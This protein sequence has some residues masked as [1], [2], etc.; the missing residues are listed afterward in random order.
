VATNNTTNQTPKKRQ[1]VPRPRTAPKFNPRAR[2]LRSFLF[3]LRVVAQTYVW[4]IFLTRFFITRWYVRRHAMD[5]WMKI[6]RRFRRLAI[7]MGGMQIKLGQFLSSRADIIPDPI[8]FE[9][10]GLQDEVPGAP[11]SHVLELIMEEHGQHPDDLFLSFDQESVAAASLGQVHYATLHD[12]SSV[13]VKVQRPYIEEIIDVDLSAV[14]WILRLIKDYPLVRK[15]ADVM[16]LYDEFAVVLRQELDYVQESHNAETLR[17]NFAGV[18]GVYI[19]QPVT[20]MTTRRV[21]VMERIS[22][23]KI[24]DRAA[25]EAAGISRY[26]L[27]DRLNQSYLKQFFLDGFF[28]ADPHP[29]NLFVR[30]EEIDSTVNGFSLFG[31]SNQTSL[32]GNAPPPGKPFTLIFVDFGMVGYL[33]PSTMAV[34]RDGVL[35]LATNDAERIV[36]ALYELNMFLPDTDKRP[37]IKIINVMLKH[38]YNRTVRELNNMDI[39]RLFDETHDLVYDMPFQI[40]K[41]LL[42]LGRAVSMVSGLATEIDPDINLFESLRPFARKMLEQE[43]QQ[44]NWV[45]MAQKEI[46]DLGTILRDLPRQMAT[47]YQSANYGELQVRTDFTRME[48]MVR[49]VERSTDRL[50]GGML[51]TGLFLGGV[52][53]RMRGMEKEARQAWM[54]AALALLWSNWPRGNGR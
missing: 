35:G 7:S 41:D 16:A 22:G 44:T 5:R 45:E 11:A 13:A 19:P 50:T 24:S 39:E 54:A 38:T 20:E 49:R 12:G 36:N 51:A 53:L 43:R 46:G 8:R 52:Q 37:I 4:D 32:N 42:Y 27:A 40:P 34:V 17:A 6:A 10:A 31:M 48:R 47:Y 25:I 21:L 18:P 33:P 23:I 3:W 30:P 14:K 28:H 29:G 26:E 15:R 2:F 1:A 9:L